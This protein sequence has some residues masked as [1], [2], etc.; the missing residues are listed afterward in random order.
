MKIFEIKIP[1][2]TKR[3]ILEKITDRLKSKQPKPRPLFIATL[4]PEILLETRK[5]KDY[6]KIV[7][8]AD[9]KLVDGFG[10]NLVAWLKKIPINDRITGADLTNLLIDKSQNL[11]KKIGIVYLTEGLSSIKDFQKNL[12]KNVLLEAVNKDNFLKKD[13]FKIK[14]TDLVLV[15]IGHPHQEVLIAKKLLS[16]SKIKIAVG[17]GGSLDYITNKQKRAPSAL[18]SFGLEWLWRLISRP[19][20]LP[21]IIKAVVIFPLLALLETK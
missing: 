9:L 11:N 18:R 17:V 12:P 19:N 21:R 4:N 2:Y 20:R 15:S 14:K 8:S 16:K 13:Y 1:N 10:I 6:Q 7:N 5:N 3:E